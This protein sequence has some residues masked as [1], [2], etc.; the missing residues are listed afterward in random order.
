MQISKD[1]AVNLQWL[2]DTETDNKMKITWSKF[3]LQ[4]NLNHHYNKRIKELESQV[5]WLEMQ[6][7][8][9]EDWIRLQKKSETTEQLKWYFWGH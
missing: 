2:F 7:E 5:K 9:V 8:N 4:H 3:S 1:P 6:M